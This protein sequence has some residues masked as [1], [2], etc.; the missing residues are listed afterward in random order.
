MLIMLHINE[1]V[2]PITNPVLILSQFFSAQFK[3]K[4]SKVVESGGAEAG[5]QTV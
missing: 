4:T 1:I 2:C 5:V 3:I